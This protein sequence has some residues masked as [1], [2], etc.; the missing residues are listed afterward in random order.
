MANAADEKEINKARRRAEQ[1]RNRELKDIEVLLAQP[2]G[3]RFIARMLTL[4]RMFH[5]SFTGNSTTFYYEG[6]RSIGVALAKDVAQVDR[7]AFAELLHDEAQNT[8]E[9]DNG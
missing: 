9:T 1:I 4:A 8:P 7:A 6:K 3:R 5:E 2:E